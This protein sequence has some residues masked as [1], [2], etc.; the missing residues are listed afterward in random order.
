MLVSNISW[1]NAPVCNMLF[2]FCHFHDLLFSLAS[3]WPISSYFWCSLSILN[4]GIYVFHHIWDI[5]SHYLFNFFFCLILAIFFLSLRQDQLLSAGE[6]WGRLVRS[7]DFGA[8][9]QTLELI[10]GIATQRIGDM[11]PMS[12]LCKTKFENDCTAFYRLQRQEHI[13]FIFKIF[14]TYPVRN[15]HHD[16]YIECSQCTC[17]L[18]CNNT[19]TW[20]NFSF[21]FQRQSFPHQQ[22]SKLRWL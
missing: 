15:S 8:L 11:F 4:L 3:V 14:L 22:D 17:W 10:P 6:G 18:K 13:L 5:F 20:D 16:L 9:L 21:I 12:F 7:A 19:N 1:I 2:S